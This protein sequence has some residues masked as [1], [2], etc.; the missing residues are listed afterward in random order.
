MMAVEFEDREVGRAVS[1]LCRDLCLG[2]MLEITHRN[3]LE[4]PEDR[5]FDVIQKKTAILFEVGCGLAARLSGADASVEES[6]RV[7]ARNLGVAFQVTDDC[8]DLVGEEGAMGKSLGNDVQHG[9]TT[10]PFLHFLRTASD[11]DRARFR[12]VFDSERTPERGRELL[13]LLESA[14]S[15]AHAYA[16][17]RQCTDDA[18]DALSV[19]EATQ[20]RRALEGVLAFVVQRIC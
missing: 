7:F 10:L 14:G 16:R 20:Y 5:Y 8:L 1:R 12:E 11:A 13:S 17:A 9:M 2:E 6:L 4:L 18:R 3:D 15:I 19:L